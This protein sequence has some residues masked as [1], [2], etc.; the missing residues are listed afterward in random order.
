MK[1][2]PVLK[3]L[4][5]RGNLKMLLRLKLLMVLVFITYLSASARS[6]DTSDKIRSKQEKTET[7]IS[8][9]SQQPIQVSGKIVDDQNE[10]LPGVTVFVKG[11]TNIGTIT[12]ADGMYTLSIP[13][14]DTDILMVSFIGMVTQEIEVKGRPSINITMEYEVNQIN[15]VVAIAYGSQKKVTI[16][17]SVSSIGGD[18]L[19]KT[20]TGSVANAL[21]G[22]VT[23]LSSV[24]YSGEPGADAADIYIRGVSTLNGASPLIQVDGVERDFN[25]IDPNE[26]ES[27]TVLKDASATAVFGVRGANGV[28]LITTKRGKEGSAKINVSTSFGVQVPTKLLEFA[29]SYQYASFYNEAQTNDGVDPASLKFQPNVLE[30]FRT[31]SDPILY[32]DMD[33]MDYLLKNGAMQSQHNVSISGGTDKVRYFVSVGAFTQEGLF[34]TFDVGY[35]FN[36]DYNRYN[37]RA[38]LDFDLTKTTLLSVNLGGRVDNRTTPISNEDQNQLFRQLYWATPFGGAGI[39]DGKRIVTNTDYVPG[40]GVDGLSSYY[41]KGYNTR[42]TN[43]LSL[44]LVLNQKLDYITK[45]LSFKV[46]GSYN[47]N[48]TQL[49]ARTSS[50]AY[51]TPVINTEGGIDYRKS[52]DDGELGYGESYSQGR[53]WYAEASLN[54]SR[55]YGNHNIGGL[56]LYTQSKTYYPSTN[57]DI[58]SGYVGLVGRVTYDFKTRYMAE[59]NVGYNGSENFAPGRR[60]GFFPAGSV[61]WVATEEP[62]MEGIKTV[63]NYMKLRASYGVVGNDSFNGRRFLYLPDSYVIGGDGYNFGTNVSSNQS[64]AYENA[65]SNPF[66]TWEKA[67]KQNYGIDLS[68]LHEN[69]KISADFFKEHR[70]DILWQS[71]TVPDIVGISLPVLNLGIVDSHGYEFTAKWNQNLTP[72][73]RYWVEGNVSFA[74]NKIIEKGEARPNEDYMWETGRPIGSYIIRKFWGF[75]D[76]TAN[77]RYKAQYGTDIAE[78]AGGLEPGD[79]VYV[80]L[81][82]DGIINSDDVTKS[83]YTNVPEYIIGANMGFKWKN[84]DFSMQWTGATH[85]S[86]LLQE[87]FREPMGDTN[88]KGLLLYQYEER[89]TPETASTATLPRATLAHKT[90]NYQSSDLFLVNASYLRLK[91]I[92]VGYTIK[93]SLFNRLG[94]DNCRV[95]VNGYNLLT[96]SDFELGDPESRT[97]SR[98]S[99]PLTRVFNMGLKV[100]F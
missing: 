96:F 36:F 49:K 31:H 87:T 93:N 98:P 43:A 44:D 29:N 57:T 18:D 52:G 45:G 5:S 94:I 41:G 16:T 77:E 79:V 46:K 63:V 12:D 50:I 59:F 7:N 37:Y 61:G 8:P 35:D 17:G 34:K 71:E 74:R 95:Y 21:S 84:L 92:E 62:F 14:P 53:N 10:P 100:G 67:Y 2:K 40:P 76:E 48:Y 91:N 55:S 82:N 9:T 42:N 39:V 80:D 26:I 86:R 30:A 99:Y 11:T 73:F 19:L 72:D 24:Q 13:N 20:P 78:H 65:K 3:C 25:Q 58:P 4:P 28:I 38:N 54:Y 69:L 51:Y 23:G 66:V 90:N 47:S 15:E 1:Q 88:E 75:Y 89:W 83:G 22:A 64:G 81:N 27:I 56:A 85:V 32:P 68:F 70:E 6:D 33:W 60:Y 97:S